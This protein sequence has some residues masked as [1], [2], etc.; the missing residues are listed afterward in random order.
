MS[1]EGHTLFESLSGGLGDAKQHMVFYP[2][3]GR[4]GI[5][6]R[7]GH[8]YAKEFEALTGLDEAAVFK[9]KGGVLSKIEACFSHVAHLAKLAS[10]NPA[11]SAVVDLVND[12]HAKIGEPPIYQTYLE[13]VSQ[14]LRAC[15]PA[16]D[17][18]LSIPEAAKTLGMACFMM[19]DDRFDKLLADNSSEELAEVAVLIEKYH[20][21]NDESREGPADRD[22]KTPRT[23]N[24]KG[25]GGMSLPKFAA[26]LAERVGAFEEWRKEAPEP[27]KGKTYETRLTGYLSQKKFEARIPQIAAEPA[28]PVDFDADYEAHLS[29]LPQ[30]VQ[31]AIASLPPHSGWDYNHQ[32]GEF[33]W[34]SNV[35]PGSE[36]P[37][38]DV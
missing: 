21:I 4:P 1:D 31:D 11:D 20:S 25:R 16:D 22:V 13:V 36:T 3:P 37:T 33:S 10:E 35:A 17:P 9:D 23:R 28:P 32:T 14:I 26:K 24:P 18:L 6:L 8:S 12:L 29:T 2:T 27:E 30:E 15:K 5:K 34:H 7:I 38:D 19:C